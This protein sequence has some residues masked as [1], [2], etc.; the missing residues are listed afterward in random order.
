MLKRRTDLAVEAAQEMGFNEI[1]FD[2]VRFPDG[3]WRYDK[4]EIDYR[5]LY[6]ESKAQA[7]Q[8]FLTYACDRLHAQ[9]VYVSADVFGEC[10]EDYV[11]AYGQYW[12]A[13]SA[14]VDAISGMPYPDHYSAT[15]SYR[16]WEHPYET[17]YQ[18][19]S[20]AAQ[21][22]QETASPAVVRTWIQCYNAI[23]EPY[24]TYGPDE[25][26]AQIKALRDTG[27][28]GGYMTWNAASSAAKYRSLMAAF[29]Q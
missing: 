5:N 29:D 12:P 11:T 10:A 24:N 3:T 21:R 28:S 8:R 22:Q 18:F 20:M 15:G 25:V 26:G 4:D 14:V 17:L 1:Q 23:R 16:P 2:Y 13:I 6:Q 19:G 27:C 9:G 7:I